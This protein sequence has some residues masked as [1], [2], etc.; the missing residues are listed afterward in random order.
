MSIL[1]NLIQYM[2]QYHITYLM[3]FYDY[4]K[5]TEQLDNNEYKEGNK[6]VVPPI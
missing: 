2:T 6:E 5:V 3:L 4:L 1:H